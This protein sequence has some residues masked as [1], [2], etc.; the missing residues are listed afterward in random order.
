MH[1]PSPMQ[2]LA[3]TGRLQGKTYELLC[4]VVQG[5]RHD[6]EVSISTNTCT[7]LARAEPL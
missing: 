2:V 7:P 6:A 3:A 4:Q 1:Q 5:R